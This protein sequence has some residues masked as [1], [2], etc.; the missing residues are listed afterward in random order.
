[1]TVF[2]IGPNCRTW[3][4]DLPTFKFNTWHFVN[5][6]NGK[7]RKNLVELARLMSVAL[8]YKILCQKC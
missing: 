6:R 1:M 5:T 3:S 7:R 2:G 4:R 8:E